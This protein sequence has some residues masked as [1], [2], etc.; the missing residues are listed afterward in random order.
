LQ[1]AH[2]SVRKFTAHPVTDGELA[3]LVAA[4]QSASTSSNLQPWSVVAIRDPEHKA[5]LAALA[6]GQQFINQAPLFLVWIA[7]LGRV[8][9]LAE[10]SG[11]PLDGADY[12]ESTLI[13]FI[14]TA[15]AAQNAVIA[16]ES[17]GLP[18]LPQRAVL[19]HER[20]DAAAADAHIPAYD[21]PRKKPTTPDSYCSF[22]TYRF[23]YI[24]STHSTSNVTCPDRTSAA[25]RAQR[26]LLKHAPHSGGCA[27]PACY[28]TSSSAARC[29][30]SVR[31]R[32]RNLRYSH[33]ACFLTVSVPTCS[34]AAIS[35]LV[36]AGANA[37]QGQL[38]A[39]ALAQLQR[40]GHRGGGRH[41][42]GLR[43]T[44]CP[45]V[46]PGA[47]RPPA[48]TPGSYAADA[49]RHRALS[50]IGIVGCAARSGAV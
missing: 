41:R 35:R 40:V 1:L 2:R 7:D 29:A 33:P 45:G 49:A 23:R 36:A 26:A 46:N 25:L 37:N 18:R 13:A 43:E 17:L 5:R 34:A 32:T 28:A 42:G 12:L 30:A 9:R 47:R 44:S 16:A 22:G 38:L 20:Y 8:H 10:R 4:A 3:A 14:D 19:H 11:R 31:F 15:L 27:P 6:N 24:R 48:R 50:T 21:Q 39:L